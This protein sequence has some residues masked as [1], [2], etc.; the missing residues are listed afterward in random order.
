MQALEL[1]Q[2]KD[3][4]G[5][6]LFTTVGKPYH[7]HLWASE[8]VRMRAS[9]IDNTRLAVSIDTGVHPTRCNVFEESGSPQAYL[10]RYRCTLQPVC[11]AATPSYELSRIKTPRLIKR[12]HRHRTSWSSWQW[13]G[14]NQGEWWPSVRASHA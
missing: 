8:V 11:H 1:V 7:L 13:R 5:K 3:P 6:R 14:S 4:S 10:V 9:C 2:I 12:V